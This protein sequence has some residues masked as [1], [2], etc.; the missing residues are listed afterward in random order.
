MAHTFQLIDGR[1]SAGEAELLLTELAQAKI[2]HHMRRMAWH[3][4]SE[5]DIKAME[6][7]IREIETDLRSTLDYIKTNASADTGVDIE[8][9]IALTLPA[10]R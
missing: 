3:D 6:K 7:R 9:T 2:Q 4:H 10:K 1:F 8:G 5:E